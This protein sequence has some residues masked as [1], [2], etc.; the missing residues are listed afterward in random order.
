MTWLRRFR[1][2]LAG[3]RF[4]ALY[5]PDHEIG[6]WVCRRCGCRVWCFCDDCRR[7]HAKL[8]EQAR[9]KP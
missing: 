9:A 2:W 1:C 6:G 7:R 8:V 4:A 5:W 3:H